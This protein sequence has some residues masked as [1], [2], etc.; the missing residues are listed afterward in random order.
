MGQ[1][2]KELR[3][4]GQNSVT[5]LPLTCPPNTLPSKLSTVGASAYHSIWNYYKKGT[6]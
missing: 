2:V 4:N 6:P 1:M 3:A 5:I